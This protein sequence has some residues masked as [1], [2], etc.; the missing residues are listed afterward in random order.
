MG[1]FLDHAHRHY[2]ILF[3]TSKVVGMS[4]D[5]YGPVERGREVRIQAG[6]KF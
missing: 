2:A 4:G 3:T 6:Y 1:I 5:L